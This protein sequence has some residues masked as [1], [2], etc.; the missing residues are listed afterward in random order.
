MSDLI[1]TRGAVL[2]A[3]KLWVLDDDDTLI[4]L[5]TA[6]FQT[7]IGN[8]GNAALKTK[9]SGISGAVGAGVEPTGT[10]NCTITWVSGDLDV[11][12]GNY[13]LEIKATIGASPRFFHRRLTI[14]NVMS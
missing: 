1:Y 4:D 10:P 8:R 3:C 5:S 12:P 2:P 7:K 9:S 13:D 6:T 14:E 11:A